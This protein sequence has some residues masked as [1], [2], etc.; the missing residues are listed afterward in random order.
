MLDFARR[1][2]HLILLVGLCGVSWSLASVAIADDVVAAVAAGAGDVA[3]AEASAEGEIS[4][5]DQ[6]AYTI[7]TLIMF[8]CA[9][10]VLFMQAGFAMLEVGLNAA[11]NT[12]ST[13]CSRT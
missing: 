3:P 7:N 6:T 4:F 11:K 1:W 2:R 10:L 9:V 8:I 13:S 5:E 12:R